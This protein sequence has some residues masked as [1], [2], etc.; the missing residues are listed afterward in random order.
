MKSLFLKARLAME[1]PHINRALNNSLS[2][3]P[4][5]AKPIATHIINAGGKR[6]RPF[7]TVLSARMFNYKNND[8]YDLAVCMEMLHVATL[9]HDD[10]LDNAISRRGKKSAHTIFSVNE[11]ILAGDALL[12]HANMQV[13]KFN[14]AKLCLVFAE[15]TSK[16]A[17]G[18]IMEIAAIKNVHLS[19]QEYLEIIKAK[20][21][22]L[23]RS[24][25]QMG[26]ILANADNDSESNIAKYGENLGIAFQI[27]DDAL[28]FES[29]NITGKPSGN[30]IKEGK[31]TLP[32]RLYRESL[33]KNDK[34]EF[35]K[36]FTKKMIS[37]DEIKDIANKVRE[38]GFVKQA[39]QNSD[40]YLENAKKH[41]ENLP[42]CDEHSIFIEM[43]N[44][45]RE[46]KK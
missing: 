4:D 44:H 2:Q 29:E 27:V 23:I 9:L 11:V 13:A 32:L 20:T 16:T 8:I 21:A 40:L 45:I 43:T 38:L 28:D 22:W 31:Y 5:P 30:D 42:K 17:I 41:L 24:S 3:L 26:A 18:E 37:D 34:N 6:L 36:I 14:N 7:L 25:C 1:L 46:R 39:C 33:N 12:S 19:E 35:D 15:A 10:V